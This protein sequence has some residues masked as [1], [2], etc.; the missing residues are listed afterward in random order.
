MTTTQRDH[1]V[2]RYKVAGPHGHTAPRPMQPPQRRRGGRAGRLENWR[3]EPC[4]GHVRGARIRRL[5]AANSRA[6]Q[7]AGACGS[8][9]HV[10]A[11]ASAPQA[12]AAGPMLITPRRTSLAGRPLFLPLAPDLDVS[13]P[14][15]AL[16]PSCLCSPLSPPYPRHLLA[17]RGVCL[18]ARL[19]HTLA[20]AASDVSPC[21]TS[22]QEH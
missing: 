14:L 4:V 2:T 10:S 22:P 9:D 16:P 5:P 3:H 12:L 18:W 7:E 15:C 6:R 13:P 20:S 21:R 1:G 17:N 8:R 11:V 19:A